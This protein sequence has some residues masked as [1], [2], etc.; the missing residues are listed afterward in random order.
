MTRCRSINVSKND[1]MTHI[2]GQLITY[3]MTMTQSRLI[4]ISNNARM[5]LIVGQ[6]IT[7]TI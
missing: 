2:V 3:N 4:N 5:T 1:R 7:I 6:L